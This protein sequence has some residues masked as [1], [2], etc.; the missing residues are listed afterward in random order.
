[1][2]LSDQ[3][4]AEWRRHGYAV[5]ENFFSPE[6]L[7]VIQEELGKIFPTW[8]QYTA[9]PFLYKNDPG[10]GHSRELPFLGDALNGVAV[11]PELIDFVER[12]LD[13]RDVILTQSI[14]WAK[15][16]G[17]DEF[18]QALHVDY[19]N[20]SILHPS[21]ADAPE[22][23]TILIYYCDIDESLG[24]TSVI[25]RDQTKDMPLVPYIRPRGQYPELYKLEQPLLVPAGSLFIYDLSTFHRGSS[26]TCSRGVRI[27][28]H[29]AYRRGDAPW[30]GYKTWANY[31]LAAEMHTVLEQAS[32]RQREVFGFP[33]PGHGYWNE[34][35]LVGTAARY[36][37]MNLTPY[38]EAASVSES[39]VR[40][41][42]ERMKT[43]PP[44]H[45]TTLNTGTVTSAG[46][47][48]EA[49]RALREYAPAIAAYYEGM[50]DP[51]DA[52]SGTTAQPEALANGPVGVPLMLNLGCGST[53][54]PGFVNVDLVAG[55]GVQR[56]NLR[57]PWPWPNDSAEYVYAPHVIEHLPDK[58][59]TMNELW[60][61]L[62][63]G[64]L[65]LILIPTTGGP[66]AWQDPTHV[67]FWNRRSFLYYEAGS[68]YREAFAASYGIHAKF[69][70]VWEAT[71]PT[72]DGP[73]L[74]IVLEAVKP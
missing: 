50:L 8:E 27:T 34:A 39:I 3:H 12:A 19:M 20:N 70:R 71:T 53:P 47:A 61:V 33:A 15:Y 57:K 13:V 10:G 54:L 41:E 58:I 49:L 14:V 40:A 73:Q 30:V 46:Y 43:V 37:N 56:V 63:P 59:F 18:D 72:A 69:R 74:T 42:R 68:P 65:A 55:P 64:G 24:P 26:L 22:Q 31:G 9:A 36:P 5:V 4:L 52:E 48:R 28:H 25:P 29:I 38:L 16:A 2:P 7:A 60:R 66:G 44:P 45:E 21:G 32:P 17:T 11:H 67:S 6:E 1:M 62:R 51:Y 23:V 35:T